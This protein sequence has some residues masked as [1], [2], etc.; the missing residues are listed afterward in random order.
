M[1]N[2]I[3]YPFVVIK[4]H[5]RSSDLCLELL[6]T[7]LVSETLNLEQNTMTIRYI[8]KYGAKVELLLQPRI[9]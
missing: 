4:F 1:E 3:R 8:F 9:K 7:G 6:A 5:Q 2:L